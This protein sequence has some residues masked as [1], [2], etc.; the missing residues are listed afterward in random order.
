MVKKNLIGILLIMVWSLGKIKE[1]D[2]VKLLFK[3]NE[4]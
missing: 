3:N 1:D 4:V 2:T